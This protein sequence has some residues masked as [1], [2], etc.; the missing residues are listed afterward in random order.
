MTTRLELK[1][2]FF[3]AY[4]GFAD[5]RYKKLENN[6]PFIVD[7]RSRGDHD[8]QGQLFLWFCMIFAE[9]LDGDRIRVK[10]G[11]GVPQSARVSQWIAEHGGEI[12]E[13]HIGYSADFE[14]SEENLDDLLDLADRVGAIIRGHYD[15]P[16]YKYVVPRT[17]ASLLRLHDL[18]AEVWQ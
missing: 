10:L 13:G 18:L 15:T 2:V 9:V 5:K 8:A 1:R 12:E 3:E 6:Q 7:D 17:Q 16:A 11:G 14:V 4:D